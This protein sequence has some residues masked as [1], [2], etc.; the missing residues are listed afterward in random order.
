[1]RLLAYCILA[2]N[3]VWCAQSGGNVPELTGTIFLLLFGPY[4]CTM[5]ALAGQS[6]AN[7]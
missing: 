6:G 4:C 3:V 1:M 7:C 5:W 2:P